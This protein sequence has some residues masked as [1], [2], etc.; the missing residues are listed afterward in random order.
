MTLFRL[1][2]REIREYEFVS[3]LLSVMGFTGK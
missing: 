1:V 2:S 3:F